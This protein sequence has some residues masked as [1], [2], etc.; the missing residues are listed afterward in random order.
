MRKVLELTRVLREKKDEKT[1]MM[2]IECWKCDD[3]NDR[4]DNR[5]RE[6]GISLM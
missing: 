5:N 6:K 4:Y 1:L 2:L 3:F